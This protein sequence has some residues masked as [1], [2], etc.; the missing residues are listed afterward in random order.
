MRHVYRYF[1]R[2]AI[3]NENRVESSQVYLSS[4]IWFW[5]FRILSNVQSCALIFFFVPQNFQI[6]SVLFSFQLQK[7]ASTT[8]KHLWIVLLAIFGIGHIAD[9]CN[10]LQNNLY[11]GHCAFDNNTM[12]IY[13]QVV[14]MDNVP[15]SPPAPASTPAQKPRKWYDYI[16]HPFKRRATTTS[17]PPTSFGNRNI[18]NATITFPPLVSSPNILIGSGNFTYCFPLFTPGPSKS[19][20]NQMH[21]SD[22]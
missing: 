12:Q 14:M 4:V 21:S 17:P 15:P 18:I 9:Y 6:L 2:R 11:Y 16:L 20:F 19:P 22:W 1:Y 8:M 5:P 7:C 13:T 10:A 3:V